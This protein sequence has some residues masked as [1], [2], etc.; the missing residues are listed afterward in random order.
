[1]YNP[2]G[3]NQLW[4][5]MFKKFATAKIALHK[6]PLR[7][8]SNRC[9]MLE[10][11]TEVAKFYSL[12]EVDGFTT[13]AIHSSNFLGAQESKETRFADSKLC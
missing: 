7:L 1:M 6:H 13:F 10:T 3:Q 8:I 9:F 5:L 4:E 12:T 2:T 11:N